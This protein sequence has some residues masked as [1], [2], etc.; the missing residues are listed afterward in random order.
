[1][2]RKYIIVLIVFLLVLLLVVFAFNHKKSKTNVDLEDVSLE[3]ISNPAE[4]QNKVEEVVDYLEKKSITLTSENVR[5]NIVGSWQSLDNTAYQV[6]FGG[7]GEMVEKLPPNQ[8]NG[9]WELV[10]FENG[11]NSVIETISFSHDGVFLKQ[12]LDEGKTSFYYKVVQVD[13]NRL[14]LIYLHEGGILG[15]D[16]IK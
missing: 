2:N 12:N 8:T 14:V 10:D 7:S 6:E 3:N 16:R 15:F 11:P 4:Y 1:M 5:K 13:E 9:T